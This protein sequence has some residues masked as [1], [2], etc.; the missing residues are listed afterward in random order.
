MVHDSPGG[1]PED[2]QRAADAVLRKLRNFV[3]VRT[4]LTLEELRLYRK[5]TNMLLNTLAN[6]R[7]AV[8]TGQYRMRLSIRPGT[9][10]WPLVGVVLVTSVD[11]PR[12]KVASN[13]QDILPAKIP[14]SD[15]EGPL[16]PQDVRKEARSEISRGG[17]LGDLVASPLAMTD[18]LAA[19]RAGMGQTHT[20]SCSHTQPK[21]A[22]PRTTRIPQPAPAP[23]DEPKYLLRRGLKR[24]WTLVFDGAEDVLAGEK[25]VDYVDYL[26]KHPEP[27][28]GYDLAAKLSGQSVIQEASLAD[29]DHRS[30]A[31]IRKEATEC[32]R[33]MQDE[34]ASGLE[35]QEAKA[36]LEELAQAKK[37]LGRRPT[38]NSEKAV[39]AVRKAIE[40]L[41]KRLLSAKD[42]HGNPHPVFHPFGAHIQKYIWIPSSR[43]SGTR[44]SRTLAGVA[45]FFTYEPPPGVKWEG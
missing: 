5:E 12:I 7:L 2:A 27:I 40:R 16:G 36:R 26:L 1:L 19:L 44:R 24:A 14:R 10:S 34:N 38:S 33:T 8:F 42:R 11:D 30:I 29:D 32:L 13:S 25:G 23:D 17:P 41:Q 22:R 15:Q 9:A 39:R 37:A 21:R 18:E 28:H 3:D 35:Q 6:H 43:Y 31:K 4:D 45:G 20:A